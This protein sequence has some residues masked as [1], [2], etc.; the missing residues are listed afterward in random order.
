[1]KK[2]R[3]NVVISYERN[4]HE[5]QQQRSMNLCYSHFLKQNTIKDRI[6]FINWAGMHFFT[7]ILKTFYYESVR[8]YVPLINLLTT[9]GIKAT[10]YHRSSSLY[11]MQL[12]CCFYCCIWLNGFLRQ[13][14]AGLVVQS[15]VRLTSSLRGQLVKCFTTFYI[16]MH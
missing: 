14:I 15:I 10:I 4:L 8:Y 2:K 3:K 5:H 12:D 9:S 16:Q 11:L 1:M 6:C 13:S 7:D